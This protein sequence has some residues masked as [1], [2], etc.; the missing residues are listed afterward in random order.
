MNRLATL[1]VYSGLQKN[2]KTAINSGLFDEGKSG[3][4]RMDEKLPK[5]NF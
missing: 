2:V 1:A 4:I 5:E 3:N